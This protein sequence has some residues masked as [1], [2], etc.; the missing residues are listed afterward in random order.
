MGICNDI[1][2][3]AMEIVVFH[4]RCVR[5]AS[6]GS[7]L[8]LYLVKIERR[9]RGTRPKVADGKPVLLPCNVIGAPRDRAGRDWRRR[10]DDSSISATL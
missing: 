3:R 2:T 7:E 10:P 4:V 9:R 8:A 6:N 5:F 1:L